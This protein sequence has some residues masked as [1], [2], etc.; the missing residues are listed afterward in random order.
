MFGVVNIVS[1]LNSFER[2]LRLVFSA[3]PPM[4]EGWHRRYPSAVPKS[5]C[6]SCAVVT[7]KAISAMTMAN[8]AVLFC[9]F[10]IL[11]R[12]AIHGWLLRLLSD[13]LC[14]RCNTGLLGIAYWFAVFTAFVHWDLNEMKH[15]TERARLQY[16]D[17]VVRFEQGC[18]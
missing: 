5:A 3:H 1:N 2:H 11:C 16:H 10:D 17:E 18:E 7:K 12:P 14:P 6:R 4:T 8:T 9:S 15:E 13:A